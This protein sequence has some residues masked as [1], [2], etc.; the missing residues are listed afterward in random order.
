MADDIVRLPDQFTPLVAR[1]LDKIIVPVFND[2]LGI[3]ATDNVTF[4]VQFYL[5]IDRLRHCGS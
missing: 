5:L 4:R 2:P 1:N 3:G